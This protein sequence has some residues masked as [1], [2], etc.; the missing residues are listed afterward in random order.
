MTLREMF[1]DWWCK[2]TLS[3]PRNCSEEYNWLDFSIF[4]LIFTVIILLV[5]K[6]IIYSCLFIIGLFF[7]HKPLDATIISPSLLEKE[8]NIPNDEIPDIKG[9]DLEFDD[10][11]FSLE[12][13][14]YK[15]KKKT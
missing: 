14:L 9:K 1:P 13:E 7:P 12:E 8:M 2:V 4:E 3:V 11:T 10:D 15:V 5:A 6:W